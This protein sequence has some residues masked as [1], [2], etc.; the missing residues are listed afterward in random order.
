MATD[1]Q[2]RIKP[3]MP[4]GFT[5]GVFPDEIPPAGSLTIQTTE[6]DFTFAINSQSVAVLKQVIAHLDTVVNPNRTT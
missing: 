6:G 2:G 3:L 4:I 5:T 1:N